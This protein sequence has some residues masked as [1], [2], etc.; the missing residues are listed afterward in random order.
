MINS[1]GLHILLDQVVYR[2]LVELLM[3]EVSWEWCREISRESRRTTQ[4]LETRAN[5]G[6]DELQSIDGWSDN[7]VLVAG[8]ALCRKLIKEAR[9]ILSAKGRGNL[10][11]LNVRAPGERVE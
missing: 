9:S 3:S 10:A 2:V 6:Q 11:I 7:T 8:H 1:I 5:L 4:V